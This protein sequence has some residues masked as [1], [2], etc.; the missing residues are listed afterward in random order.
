[1]LKRMSTSGYGVGGVALLTL[2]LAASGPARAQNAGGAATTPVGGA[3]MTPATHPPAASAPA[4]VQPAA[5]QPAT[6]NG[7]ATE[8]DQAALQAALGKEKAGRIEAHITRL[9]NDLK[10][11]AAQEPAWQRFAGT[12]RANAVQM[13]TAFSRRQQNY[14][15]MNAVQD[16][17][18]YGEVEQ[19]NAQ[20]IAQL[21]PPF[22][23]LYG[24]LSPQ[25]QKAADAIFV[26]HI[27]KAV[28]KVN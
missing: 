20:N 13:D 9:H 26:R 10:I 22:E 6:P 4:A 17:Q 8:L 21:L 3:A 25:Q 14:A 23:A 15:S 5:V 12:M 18:S 1:M 11:T 16:L 2:A 24:A 27:D 19:I 7:A 28:K